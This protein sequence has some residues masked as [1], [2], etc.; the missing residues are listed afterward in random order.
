MQGDQSLEPTQ[1]ELESERTSVTVRI[2]GEAYNLRVITTPDYALRCAAAVDEAMQEIVSR[3]ALVDAHRAAILSALSVADRMFRAEAEVEV[4]R[5]RG[6][7][8]AAAL[9]ARIEA[10]LAPSS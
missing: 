1:P 4:E 8:R 5:E 9:A 2:G 7:E 10:R 3:A 6:A